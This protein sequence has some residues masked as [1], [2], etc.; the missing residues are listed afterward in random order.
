MSGPATPATPAR[1][2]SWQGRLKAAG[3]SASGLDSN[4]VRRR[5]DAQGEN[6]PNDAR[7]SRG[8]R[9]PLPTHIDRLHVEKSFAP[10]GMAPAY[11]DVERVPENLPAAG[12]GE[13]HPQ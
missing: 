8:W 2:A 1:T 12:S 13:A 7:R 4:E 11:R 9:I 10:Q 6:R 3:T 5:R